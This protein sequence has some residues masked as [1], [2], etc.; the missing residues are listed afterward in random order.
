MVSSLLHSASSEIS[1]HKNVLDLNTH[2]ESRKQYCTTNLIPRLSSLEPGNEV[3]VPH[4]IQLQNLLNHVIKIDTASDQN[5]DG[6]KAWE[7]G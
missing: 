3:T 4:V 6:G 5:L 7:Q 2:T 1:D